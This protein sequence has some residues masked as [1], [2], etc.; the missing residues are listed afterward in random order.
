MDKSNNWKSRIS[1]SGF[2]ENKQCIIDFLQ[3]WGME[4]HGFMHHY[5]GHTNGEREWRQMELWWEQRSRDY[6]V[7]GAHPYAYSFTW[8]TVRGYFPYPLEVARYIRKLWYIRKLSVHT[9]TPFTSDICREQTGSTDM[10]L[11]HYWKHRSEEE[12]ILW[13]ERVIGELLVVLSQG[14][15]SALSC[16][17][18]GFIWMT[19]WYTVHSVAVGD[20]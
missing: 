13:W 8:E 20:V 2:N 14:N 5:N 17:W 9:S 12:A 16:G 7:H 6:R 11:M 18:R 1:L 3:F 19:V 15:I 10:V 4:W